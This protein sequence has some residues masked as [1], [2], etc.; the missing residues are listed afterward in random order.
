MENVGLGKTR[1]FKDR[2]CNLPVPTRAGQPIH[3]CYF[4]IRTKRRGGI[5]SFSIPLQCVLPSEVYVRNI[6][7]KIVFEALVHCFFFR[8]NAYMLMK[9]SYNWL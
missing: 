1:V 7:E 3:T 4:G 5:I 9:G 8:I 2:N 6:R